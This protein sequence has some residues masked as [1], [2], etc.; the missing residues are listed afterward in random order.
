MRLPI[1]IVL[2]VM[3]LS[4]I[5]DFYIYK[6]IV[7]ACRSRLVVWVHWMFSLVLYILFIV[8]AIM[9]KDV[10][11]N[12]YLLLVM[13]M[14]FIYL[15]I[16]A[17]KFCALFISLWGYLFKVKVRRK[18]NIVAAVIGITGCA[19]IWYSAIHTR[20]SAEVTA[21]EIEFDNLPAAFD[22]YM[23][24]QFSDAHLGSYGEDT[25]FVEECVALINSL[26]ADA[27]VFTGDIVNRQTSEIEPF[28]EVLSSLS[29]EDGIFSILG[30]HD[31][32]DYMQ[33]E[34]ERDKIEDRKYL[35]DTQS[36]M[37]WTMLNNDYRVIRRGNDSIMMI[38]VENWGEPPFKIY[39]DL[40][41]AYPNLNDG[42]FKVLLSHNVV[43]W[44][45]EVLPLTNVDLTLSGHTH[46][47][48]FC[49]T[50]FGHKYSPAFLRYKEWGGLYKSDS[51]YLYVN[52]GL[53]TVAIP[54]RVGAV[55]E[56]TLI[57]LKKI[58]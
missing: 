35:V 52:I 12:D 1:I 36:D 24:A 26:G 42:N 22:G 25:E 9:P 37:G 29:A 14:M 43:H 28:I 4:V 31:Y 7:V 44:S 17:P 2:S 51:Q 34:S 13:W 23:I 19:I 45:H 40:M 56:I 30:N 11:D 15:S 47:M 21:V 58:S 5:T 49:V 55:P 57:T 32:G 8:L 54:M 3:I 27:I 20:L 46:A 50:I 33:W 48:Q 10:I 38:G 53:G 18:L 39:G 6:Q 41:S 16:Y